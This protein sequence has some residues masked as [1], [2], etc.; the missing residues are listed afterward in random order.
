MSLN[1][2]QMYKKRYGPT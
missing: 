1:P 2:K